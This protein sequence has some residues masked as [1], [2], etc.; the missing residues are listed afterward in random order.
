LTTKP[1]D[2]FNKSLFRELLSPYGQ[3]T[4]NLAVPGEE[5]AIDIFFAP[6]PAVML[7]P[8]ELGRLALMLTQPSLLEP[9]CSSLVDAE[10]GNCL[11]KLLLVH[12]DKYRQADRENRSLNSADLPQLWILAASVSNRLL[13]DF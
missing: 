13:E 10:V 9:F 12:A 7:D 4:P 8:A 5:R 1:F 2:Q 6:D 11:L 3:V